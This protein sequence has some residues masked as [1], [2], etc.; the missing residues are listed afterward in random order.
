[1]ADENQHNKS[2]PWIPDGN[3]GS[4]SLNTP[5]GC[6]YCHKKLSVDKLHEVKI[7]TRLIIDSTEARRWVHGNNHLCRKCWSYA[8]KKGI[9]IHSFPQWF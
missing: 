5:V 4:V 8:K 6:S 3:F 2:S 7:D 1:M 9:I